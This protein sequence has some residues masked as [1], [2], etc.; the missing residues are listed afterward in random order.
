MEENVKNFIDTLKIAM[1]TPATKDLQIRAR[2]AAICDNMKLVN[3]FVNQ[4]FPSGQLLNM[5]GQE[6]LCT[7]GDQVVSITFKDTPA[8]RTKYGDDL[9]NEEYYH[10]QV[11]ASV[12]ED[13][14]RGGRT[15]DGYERETTT[16]MERLEDDDDSD[17]VV[18]FKH[19]RNFVDPLYIEEMND[20]LE[21]F[22]KLLEMFPYSTKNENRD[23]GSALWDTPLKYGI[24]S[25][26]EIIIGSLYKH[27]TK[28]GDE[29]LGKRNGA[30]RTLTGRGLFCIGADSRKTPFLMLEVQPG[31]ESPTYTHCSRVYIATPFD[32][33]P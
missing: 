26:R 18:K 33:T 30:S 29:I 12:H 15:W 11:L 22:K 8:Y 24:S 5:S 31:D 28:S 20:N 7:T 9:V 21:F 17:D 32:T 25:A 13:F 10:I 16:E 23:R 14:M 3:E 27:C 1:D 4:S 19:T 2:Y 6:T